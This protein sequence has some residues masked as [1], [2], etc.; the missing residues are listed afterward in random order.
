MAAAKGQFLQLLIINKAGGLIYNQNLSGS[1]P[2]VGSNDW[3]RIGSTFHSLHAIIQQVAPIK[4]K[5][6]QKL[7]TET[8]K[9]QCFQTLTGLKIVLTASSGHLQPMLDSVLQQIYLLY[10]DYV[11]KNPFYE[12][13]MP[14][15][16]ALFTRHV[17]NLIDSYHKQQG[18]PNSQQQGGAGVGNSAAGSKGGSASSS[19]V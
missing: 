8:F 12:L 9:L 11:L 17:T 1:A 6:I 15:R 18:G 4:S 13:D 10:S 19:R 3:L 7:E 14:I 16:C 2:H 5:G